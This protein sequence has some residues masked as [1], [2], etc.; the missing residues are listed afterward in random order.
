M[1]QIKSQYK[2]NIVQITVCICEPKAVY[3]KYKKN[4]I[5]FYKC[6]KLH[7]SHFSCIMKMFFF[8]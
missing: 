1:F 3:A 5:I 8:K 2:H 6:R 7:V 4:I